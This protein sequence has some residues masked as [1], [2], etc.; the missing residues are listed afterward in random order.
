[1]RF[2]FLTVCVIFFLTPV[3]QAGTSVTQND[4]TINQLG[5]QDG[6]GSVAYFSVNQP[7]TLD[8]QWSDIYIDLT[9]DVGKAEYAE[10]LAAKLSGKSLSRVDYEQSGGAGTECIL[11]L[12][13][14][15]N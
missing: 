6:G 9:T 5:V 10:L 3:A 12:V 1:M 2:R 14:I 11:D 7:L 8:C 13:E 15:E 4:L